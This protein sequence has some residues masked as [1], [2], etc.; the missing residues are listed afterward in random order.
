MSA[1]VINDLELSKYLDRTAMRAINGGWRRVVKWIYGKD[2]K[3][4]KIV[5]RERGRNHSSGPGLG[6][7]I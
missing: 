7:S 5:V 6:L 4:K 3:L 2:G 1:L